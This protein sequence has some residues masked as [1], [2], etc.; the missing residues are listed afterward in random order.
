MFKFKEK[1][2]I[3]CSNEEI[4]RFQKFEFQ[5]NE[6]IDNL[7][8]LVSTGALI[9]SS[10]LS[11]HIE[12]NHQMFKYSWIILI[13]GILFSLWNRIATSEKTSYY[14]A[15]FHKAQQENKSSIEVPKI[16]TKVEL[17]L[18]RGALVLVSIGVILLSLAFI[19]NL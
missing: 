12:Y 5:I 19:I 2:L 13:L 14:L 7:V 3:E 9:F 6:Q 10:S 17:F 18:Y 8:I 11:S 1:Q 4:E 16:I 15:K